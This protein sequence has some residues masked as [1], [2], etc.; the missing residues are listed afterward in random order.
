MEEATGQ[1]LLSVSN[2]W[3]QPHPT[4]MREKGLSTTATRKWILQQSQEL[5]GG[6]QYPEGNVVPPTLWFQPC[7]S[8]GRESSHAWPR[9]LTDRTVS[10]KQVLF[11]AAKFVSMCY[12]VLENNYTPRWK[13]H[14]MCRKKYTLCVEIFSWRFNETIAATQLE[15][16]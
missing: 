5:E 8:K 9:L 10:Y 12:S 3:E 14:K 16:G 13:Y 4:A 1:D 6:P 11:Q 7:K 2:C 15:E